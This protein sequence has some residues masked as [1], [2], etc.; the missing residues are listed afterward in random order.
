MSKSAN[1]ELDDANL[2]FRA[3]ADDTVSQN[4]WVTSLATSMEKYALPINRADA[5]NL[6]LP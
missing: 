2:S 1:L 4:G 6:R 3:G 5:E